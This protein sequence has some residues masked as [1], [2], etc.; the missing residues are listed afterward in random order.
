MMEAFGGVCDLRS[1]ETCAALYP[2]IPLDDAWGI[3]SDP[4]VK[5]QAIGLATVADLA[6]SGV[7][8]RWTAKAEFL[9]TRYTTRL[10]E[11]AGVRA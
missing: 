7:E 9:S 11:I 8:R 4:A 1:R 10:T 5:L 6:V 3:D 2:T